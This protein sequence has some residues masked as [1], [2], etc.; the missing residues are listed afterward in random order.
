M[1]YVYKPSILK[2]LGIP[3]WEQVRMMGAEGLREEQRR[4][5]KSEVSVVQKSRLGSS[6]MIWSTLL[7]TWLPGETQS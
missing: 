4:R 5:Q 6:P 3:T 2:S 7:L 1:P